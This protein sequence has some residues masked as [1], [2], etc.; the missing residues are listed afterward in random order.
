MSTRKAMHIPSYKPRWL[1]FDG[2]IDPHAMMRKGSLPCRFCHRPIQFPVPFDDLTLVFPCG[3]FGAVITVGLPKRD[4]TKAQLQE[5]PS[6]ATCAD[7]Q[8][9]VTAVANGLFTGRTLR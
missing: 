3:L 5:L 9:K 6:V 1:T 4:D 2:Q 8:K 7:C